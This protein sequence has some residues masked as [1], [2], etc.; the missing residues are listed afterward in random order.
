MPDALRSQKRAL[1]PM[2]EEA[3]CFKVSL[4]PTGPRK[5]GE[6]SPTS[7]RPDFHM[8]VCARSQPS[9]PLVPEDLI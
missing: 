3:K 5:A 8:H 1:D 4:G 9:I 2:C 7:C 6:P